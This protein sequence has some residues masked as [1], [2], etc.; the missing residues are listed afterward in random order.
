MNLFELYTPFDK[1]PY[2]NCFALCRK[3]PCCGSTAFLMLIKKKIR[4]FC[5][6]QGRSWVGLGKSDTA[7]VRVNRNRLR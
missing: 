7:I 6:D 1:V 5:K 3:Q 2:L 4:V